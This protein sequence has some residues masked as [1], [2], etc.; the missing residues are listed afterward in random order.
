LVASGHTN[1]D[2]SSGAAPSESAPIISSDSALSTAAAAYAFQHSLLLHELHG[3]LAFY[4]REIFVG[5]PTGWS[6]ICIKVKV[7]RSA[8]LA[9]GVLLLISVVVEWVIR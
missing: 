5:A 7:S 6:S 4:E 9:L 3:K 1:S 8:C 2:L